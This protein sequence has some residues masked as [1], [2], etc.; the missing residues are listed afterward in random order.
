MQQWDLDTFETR[1][2]END[3]WITPGMIYAYA[4]I[5]KGCGYIN[6][7][8]SVN[9][10]LPA[11]RELAQKTGAVVAGKDGKTGQTL[12]KTV[13]APMFK[14]RQLKV[15]GWYSTN[16]LGNT[17][18]AVLS[19]TDHRQ[20]NAATKLAVLSNILGYEDIDHQVR[21]DYYRPRG[22]NNE[23]W[24][25]VDFEGWLGHKMCMKINWIGSDSVLAAPLVIDLVRF[26]GY[27]ARCGEKGM[28]T[29]LDMFFKSPY[30]DGRELSCDFFEQ[31]DRLKQYVVRS[32]GR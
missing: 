10:E 18:G 15:L 7:T 29:Y 24:D 5:R 11:L 22:D 20:S 32:S 6:F 16:I 17:D 23:A 21:I 9:A 25:N 26:A 14:A 2:R 30:G 1:M 4:A 3:S 13:L 31:L 8:P 12:Y 28:L 19:S 27:A